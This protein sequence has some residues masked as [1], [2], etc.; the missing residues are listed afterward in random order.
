MTTAMVDQKV[1]EKRYKKVIIFGNSFR[2]EFSPDKQ[3]KEDNNKIRK[4]LSN[5]KINKNLKFN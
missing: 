4:I 3:D 1:R 2:R 5:L